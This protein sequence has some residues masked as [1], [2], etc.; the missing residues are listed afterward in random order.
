MIS[1]E[2]IQRT[3]KAVV[4]V[5]TPAAHMRLPRLVYVT[6]DWEYAHVHAC[7]EYFPYVTPR[8]RP[9]MSKNFIDHK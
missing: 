7:N 6:K 9:S 4:C 3:K 5:A 2:W 1:A 8:N